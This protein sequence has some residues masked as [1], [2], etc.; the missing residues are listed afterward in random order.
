[1]IRLLELKFQKAEDN[2][3][4]VVVPNSLDNNCDKRQDP[5]NSVLFGPLRKET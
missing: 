5:P 4:H 3:C 1:M 2:H